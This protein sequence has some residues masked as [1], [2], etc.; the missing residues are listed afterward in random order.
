MPIDFK[1]ALTILFQGSPDDIEMLLHVP[2]N[3]IDDHANMCRIMAE[4][5]S[6]K[7][8]D[9]QDLLQ[10]LLEVSAANKGH[11]EDELRSAKVSRG[12]NA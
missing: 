11:Y 10:E 6:E 9:V 12:L 7:F 5:V 2:L 4:N 3:S 1:E 8:D